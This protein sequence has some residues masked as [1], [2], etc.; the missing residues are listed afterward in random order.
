MVCLDLRQVAIGC[1]KEIENNLFVH[2]KSTNF[3]YD[4]CLF[5]AKVKLQASGLSCSQWSLIC[6]LPRA[7]EE[8]GKQ[9]STV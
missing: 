1:E 3:K 6:G 7:F 9:I 8:D 4:F 5:R 2:T